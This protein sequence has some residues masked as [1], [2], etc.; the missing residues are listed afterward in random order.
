MRAD[1]RTCSSGVPSAASERMATLPEIPLSMPGGRPWCATARNRPDLCTEQWQ[2]EPPPVE[3]RPRR[4]SPSSGVTRNAVTE[5]DAGRA[6]R[7]TAQ[8]HACI[9]QIC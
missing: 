6:P 7:V 8:H 9:Y 3:T 2:A 1:P 5:L 4:S